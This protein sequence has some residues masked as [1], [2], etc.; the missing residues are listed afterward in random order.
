MNAVRLS[1][2]SMKYHRPTLSGCKDIG[3]TKFE[4]VAKTHFLYSKYCLGKF[5]MHS[6]IF[7]CLG[8]DKY[9]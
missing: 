3:D 1:N 8:S 6:L 7:F 4:F 9:L 2:L 5:E